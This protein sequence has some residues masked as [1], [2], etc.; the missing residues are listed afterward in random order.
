MKT[1]TPITHADD[2]DADPH[3]TPYDARSIFFA[4]TAMQPEQEAFL[5]IMVA[6]GHRRVSPLLSTSCRW[7]R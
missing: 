5:R 2:G 1:S 7:C 6:V 3:Q 4:A